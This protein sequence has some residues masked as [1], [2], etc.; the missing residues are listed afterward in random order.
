MKAL[1][2]GLFA[3]ILVT[4]AA[5]AAMQGEAT[6]A[7]LRRRQRGARAVPRRAPRA[8]ARIRA[9]VPRHHPLLREPPFALSASTEQQAKLRV[10]RSGMQ[11]RGSRRSCDRGRASDVRS[12]RREERALANAPPKVAICASS[13]RYCGQALGVAWCESRLFHDGRRTASTSASS[14][15]ART[16][17][18]SSATVRPLTQALA[19]HRYFVVSGRD[20]SPWSCKLG[21]SGRP[22]RTRFSSQLRVAR[23][24]RAGF[25]SA[26][27]SGRCP[28]YVWG[29]RKRDRLRPLDEA[30]A[31][32]RCHGDRDDNVRIVKLP[33]RRVRYEA[34][35]SSGE[36]IRRDF[37]SRARH[38]EPES[39]RSSAGPSSRARIRYPSTSATA[40]S[41]SG[42]G[43]RPLTAAARVR[44]PYGP[45]A[46]FRRNPFRT[47]PTE[48]LDVRAFPT[49]SPIDALHGED[50][51]VGG[52]D[53]RPSN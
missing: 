43:H 32:A 24:P 12:R 47:E 9:Q 44:I 11:E 42:L 52:V 7:I 51:R 41:S 50:P 48:P 8:E 5:A 38:R 16:S 6:A 25:F 13:G 33:P 31:Y 49:R 27:P 21:R 37:E 17:G 46:S 22:R 20:W 10:L 3:L 28:G 2:V 36:S 26:V 40:H 14:R 53:G 35:L 18:A 4:Q 15:W 45:R 34:V 1:F 19:A 23:T 30:A 29:Q 39:G